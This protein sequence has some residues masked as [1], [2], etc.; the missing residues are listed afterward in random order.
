MGKTVRYNLVL[1][2]CVKELQG[3]S[4][5][6][7][8][9]AFCDPPFN[10]KRKYEN[11]YDNRPR[12]DYL[13]WAT[14]WLRQVYRVLTPTGTF[15][16][17]INDEMVSEMVVLA[18]SLGF[19]KRC[20]VV[21]AYTFGVNQTGNFTKAHAHLLYYCKD[22]KTRTFNAQD[23]ALPGAEC[24]PGDLQR[25]SR[26][27][28]AGRLPDDVWIL[29]PVEYAACFAGDGDVWLNSRVRGTFKE[30]IPGHDKPDAAGHS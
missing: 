16:L 10:L 3:I 26:G 21:W 1:G 9:L 2:D 4:A 24:S 27:N 23:P 25:Q 6:M 30:K 11:W 28:P 5:G 15:W 20:G 8:D 17:A 14:Q 13:T 19:H 22:P 7:F 18:K 12:N 29:R